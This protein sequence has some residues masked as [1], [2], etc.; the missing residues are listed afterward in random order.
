MRL[1]WAAVA[2]AAAAVALCAAFVERP[3]AR[4]ALPLAVMAFV[5]G[6]VYAASGG[7]GALRVGEA[8]LRKTILMYLSYRAQLVAIAAWTSITLLIL[9][10]AGGH[11]VRIFL[12]GGAEGEAV[13]RTLLVVLVLG[14]T[15]WPIFWK[16][17]EVTAVGV[18]TE[19]W[20]GT[21]ESLVPMPNGV[22]S[23][24]FGYL[25]SRIPFTILFNVTILAALALA[26]PEG[27][28]ALDGPRA[29]LDFAAVVATSVACMW[30]LGLLFGGLA[31]LYK[32]LGPADLVMR[33]LFILLAGVFVPIQVFPAWAQWIARLLPMTYAYQLLQQVV[34]D[35]I[36]LGE[37][38]LTL[39]VLLTFT[40]ASVVGGSYVYRTY[41]EKARRKGAIQGY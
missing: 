15:T 39:G 2:L 27:M 13:S 5:G 25:M 9:F 19:Q 3:L 35:G 31:V 33:T 26:L 18:R 41:V 6:S 12:T 1:S 30:G 32:R 16:S 36:P 29:V 14:F 28:L 10:F 22:R 34:V 20:E 21:F 4:G 38:P 11:V 37:D 17:W 40:L 24:P 23:L 7:R 8:M